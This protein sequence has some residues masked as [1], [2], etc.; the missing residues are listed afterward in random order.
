MLNAKQV[1]ERLGISA[2][3]VYELAA[4][5]HLPSYRFGGAVRFAPDDV[6]HYIASC[7]VESRNTRPQLGPS[8]TV[9][10]RCSSDAE[11]VDYFRSRGIEP[12]T[13]R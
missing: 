11:L 2:R 7:R 13:R 9:R 10:L 12:R 8:L 6:D 1:A 4:S 3:K 5:G